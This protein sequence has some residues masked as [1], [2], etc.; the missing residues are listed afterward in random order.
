MS[1]IYKYFRSV[2][3]V[4]ENVGQIENV[5]SGEW[6]PNIE[7]IRFEGKTSD[8]RKFELS[9]EIEKGVEEDA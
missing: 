5:R 4:A 6:L 7:H 1:N 3:G 2:Q 8:G 9:L